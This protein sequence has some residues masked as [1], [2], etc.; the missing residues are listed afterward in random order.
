MNLATKMYGNLG[1]VE[2]KGLDFSIDYVKRFNNCLLYTSKFES[3]RFN[4][5]L[6]FSAG[7][8]PYSLLT[9]G[10]S[11]DGLGT[12]SYTHLDV[13]QRQSTSISAEMLAF[14]KKGIPFLL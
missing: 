5:H 13:Y 12:V 10:D 7:I 3:N 8:G 9:S 6:F 2:N 11:Q 4:E 14:A 1:K